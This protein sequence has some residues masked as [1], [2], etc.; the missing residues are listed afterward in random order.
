MFAATGA[1]P[2]E[3]SH[4]VAK[5]LFPWWMGLVLAIL[6]AYSNHFENGFQFDD[7]HTVVQNASI[8]SLANLPRFFSDASTFSTIPSA[9]SYRPLVTASLALD[10]ALG[11]GYSRFG[12]TCSRSCGL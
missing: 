12:S 11:G 8:R 3:D 2:S 4:R 6:A 10:Y 1:R 5:G 7:T 9:W